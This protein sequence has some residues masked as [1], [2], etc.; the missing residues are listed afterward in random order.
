MV[1]HLT[2]WQQSGP[3]SAH[4]KL[5]QFLGGLLPGMTQYHGLAFERRQRYEYIH[6]KISKNPKILLGAAMRALLVGS[7]G[8]IMYDEKLVAN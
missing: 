3:S 1:A 4:G 8:Y 6:T 5:C 2:V 7:D